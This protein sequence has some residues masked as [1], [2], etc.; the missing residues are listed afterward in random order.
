MECRY[1]S[2]ITDIAGYAELL[3]E[4]G[5]PGVTLNLFG[6]KAEAFSEHFQF[7]FSSSVSVSSSVSSSVSVSSGDRVVGD[8]SDTMT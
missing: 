5:F 3:R 4:I 6:I 1:N 7:P 2:T 8:S